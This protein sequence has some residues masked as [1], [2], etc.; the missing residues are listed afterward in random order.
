M[1]MV[2]VR[3]VCVATLFRLYFAQKQLKEHLFGL[4]PH[5]VEEQRAEQDIIFIYPGSRV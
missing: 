4:E 3:C 2:L 5:S 1:A